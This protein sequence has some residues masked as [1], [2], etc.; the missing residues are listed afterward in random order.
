MFDL[1]LPLAYSQMAVIILFPYMF[2]ATW[3]T[4]GHKPFQQPALKSGHNNFTRV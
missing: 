2:P 4:Q 1:H 3:Q